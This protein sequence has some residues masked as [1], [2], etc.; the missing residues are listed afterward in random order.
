MMITLLLLACGFAVVPR[1]STAIGSRDLTTGWFLRPADETRDGGAAVSRTGYDTTGWKPVALPSTVLAALVANNLYKDIYVGTNLRSVPDLTRRRWWF[2]GEF[3]I[4][5]AGGRHV[6]WLRFKG[7]S[8]RAQIWLNGRLLDPG[9]AG[10][11]VVHEYDVSGRL[12]PGTN[13]LAVLV[14]PPRHH[15]ADLSFCTVD[16]NPEAP[17]MNAGLWGKTSIITSGPVALREPYVKTKLPLPRTDSADLTVYVEAVNATNRPV[18][19]TVSGSVTKPGRPAVIF[20]RNL[21][22]KP[23]ERREIAFTPETHPALHLTDPALWW[24]HRFGS[25]ELYR[26]TM[27][28]HT[29]TA[30]SDIAA[31]HFGIRQFTAYRTV[32]NGTSFVGYRVNGRNLLFRG[33]GYTWDLLQRWDT[34]T[35]AT[36]IRYAKEMGLNM[37]RLEG[38]LGNEELYD[39]ADRSGILIMAG[40]ACCSAWENDRGWSAEQEHIALASLNSQMRALRTHPSAFVWAYGSDKPVSAAHLAAYKKIAHHLHW[41]NPTLD[42]VAT[43]S[44]PQAGVKMDGPYQWEPPVLWWDETRAGGASGTTAE[45]GTEV[46]PPLESL[47]RFI[48]PRDLWPIGS[49]WNYHAGR[50]GSPFASIAPFTLAVMRRYGEVTDAPGYARKAE[51]QAYE[52]IRSFFEAW[53][54]HQHVKTFGTV[55]W[56]LDS[57]WPS[58]RWSLYDY[59][60]KPG[61]GYFGA[62]KANEPVHIMYDYVTRDV[63]VANST[64]SAR[65]GLSATVTVYGVPNLTTRYETRVT[66]DVPANASTRL[67]TI[68]ALTGLPTT[69]LIRLRLHDVHGCVVSRNLYWYSASPDVLSPGSDYKGTP[70]AAYADLSGLNRLPVNSHL[71]AAASRARHGGRETVTIILTNASATDIA[72]FVRAE[73][74][75]GNS[76]TEILPV[77]YSDN[78]VSLW[79]GERTIITASYHDHDL[80]GRPLRLRLGGHNVPV[81]STPIP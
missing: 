61:G 50:P 7:I 53:N 19:A 37:I 33:G 81:T 10:S 41:P 1:H 40:F 68:P 78:Y 15:C 52:T 34:R 26:L 42:N 25:P 57:A 17:D 32:V 63:Y 67:T 28:A 72:F 44:N 60:F 71:S 11:M 62:K 48:P 9:A 45:A 29:G 51:L 13:A 24:P 75:A 6:R 73:L 21:R 39:L 12:R 2:R 22:L 5:A 36:H 20:S 79:P 76:A 27:S 8:Y 58:M 56:M 35:N 47:R 64:L 74:T 55:F 38:T 23:G 43:W 16:W 46:P 77:F 14:T 66:L 31:I 18:D 59:Y 54:A 70:A 69:Y 49:V 4:A 30:L 3:T 80:R 65:R